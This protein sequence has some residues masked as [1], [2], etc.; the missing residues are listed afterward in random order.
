MIIHDEK[1][2]L[3]GLHTA[4]VGLAHSRDVSPKP[5]RMPCGDN[6]WCSLAAEGRASAIQTVLITH[7]IPDGNDS[8]FANLASATMQ[9]STQ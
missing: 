2:Q 5:Q 6:D 8:R 3:G 7:A 9:D 4:A 1:G